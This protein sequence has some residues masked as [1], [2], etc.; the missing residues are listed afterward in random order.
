MEK[1]V[2]EV[3]YIGSIIL[4]TTLS[5]RPLAVFIGVVIGKLL[6]YHKFNK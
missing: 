5:Q 6:A 2:L 4:L 3:L 1:L